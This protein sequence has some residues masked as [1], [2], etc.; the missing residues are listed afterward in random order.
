MLSMYTNQ[1]QSRKYRG[2]PSESQQLQI[3]SPSHIHRSPNNQ[4]LDH[5]MPQICRE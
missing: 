1:L 2:K 4:L 5:E 3:F